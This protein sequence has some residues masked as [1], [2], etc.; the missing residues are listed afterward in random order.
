MR[1]TISYRCNYCVIYE[2]VR[3]VDEFKLFLHWCWQWRRVIDGSTGKIRGKGD[4]VQNLVGHPRVR[5]AGLRRPEAVRDGAHLL[6][7]KTRLLG[8]DSPELPDVRMR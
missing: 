1:S 8:D 7:V 3:A 4:S 6:R 5:A 2:V